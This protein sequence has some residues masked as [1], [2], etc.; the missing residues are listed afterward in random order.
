[1]EFAFTHQPFAMAFTNK[2][3]RQGSWAEGNHTPDLPVLIGGWEGAKE[4]RESL[5]RSK[6]QGC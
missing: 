2:V 6:G 1:M 3:C 5:P 4:L